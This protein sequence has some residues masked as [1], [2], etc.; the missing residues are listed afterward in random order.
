MNNMPTTK[1]IMVR[2]TVTAKVHPLPLNNPDTPTKN[3]NPRR[4]IILPRYTKNPAGIRNMPFLGNEIFV[5]LTS[6]EKDSL[7][8][9][10]DILDPCKLC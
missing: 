8:M 7:E 1:V 9:N 2:I 6:N 4:F 5:P 3:A 10:G